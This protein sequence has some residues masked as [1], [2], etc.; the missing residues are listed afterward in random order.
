M[1]ILMLLLLKL[2]INANTIT[3]AISQYIMS[4]SKIIKSFVRIIRLIILN[5]SNSKPIVIPQAIQL[6]KI[7][8]WSATVIFNVSSPT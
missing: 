4:C 7:I 6:K 8:V 2:S 3:E 1:Q 5:K